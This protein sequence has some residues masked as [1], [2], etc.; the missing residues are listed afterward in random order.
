[1]SI[2]RE[3]LIVFSDFL[4]EECAAEIFLHPKCCRDRFGTF[5]YRYG[6]AAARFGSLDRRFCVRI[7]VFAIN[8]SFY[9]EKSI[10]FF[11]FR[12]DGVASKKTFHTRGCRDRF[13]KVSRWYW[14]ATVQF[15]SL[16][17]PICRFWEMS[18]FR[19]KLT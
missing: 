18:I 9:R 15:G 4:Q 8:C 1:M 2:Y 5:W 16:D 13:R 19:D 3:K 17:R 10:V 6:P 12:Q 11:D 7:C 14:P